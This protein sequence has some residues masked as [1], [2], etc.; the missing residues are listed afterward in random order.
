M[1]KKERR[2]EDKKYISLIVYNGLIY[3]TSRNNRGKAKQ[4]TL[5]EKTR[6]RGDRKIEGQRKWS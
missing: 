1:R 5:I 4:N 3:M 2:N 6:W